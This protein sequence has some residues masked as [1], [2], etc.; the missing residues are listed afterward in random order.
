MVD[1]CLQVS[2]LEQVPEFV[3]DV[4]VVDVHP[5]R[6]QLEGRPSCLDPLRAVEGVDPDVV[7]RADAL[8]RQVM[9]EAVRP[10]FQ[11]RVGT[12]I[13]ACYQV[14]PLAERIGRRLEQ[15]REIELH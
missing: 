8:R 15:V 13:V 7:A 6:T 5:D 3:F 1:E 2:V 4:P 12:A 9:G 14:L 10:R 11:L